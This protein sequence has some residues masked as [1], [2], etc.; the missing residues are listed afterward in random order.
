MLERQENLP[1]LGVC[2]VIEADDGITGLDALRLELAEGRAV[3]LVLLDYVMINMDGPEAAKKIRAEVVGYTG[4]VIGIT[5]NALPEDIAFFKAHGADSVITKP[6]TFS[7]TPLFWS[8][9]VRPYTRISL[10][11][12]SVS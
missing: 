8:A 2:E 11:F 1:V 6:L 12:V 9:L 3:D 10:D 4:P 5:G 7:M